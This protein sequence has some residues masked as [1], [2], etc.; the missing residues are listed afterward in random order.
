MVVHP[1][2]YLYNHYIEHSFVFHVKHIENVNIAQYNLI[3]DIIEIMSYN[4]LDIEKGGQ[5]KRSIVT[6]RHKKQS[7]IIFKRKEMNYE[8]Y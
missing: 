4:R 7:N 5:E 1:R 2:Y 3:I 6:S 8:P